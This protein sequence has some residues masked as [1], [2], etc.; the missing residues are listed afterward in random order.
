[1]ATVG[2]APSFAGV[3]GAAALL[4]L[5]LT[6]SPLPR[7]WAFQAVVSG[8][9]MLLGYGAGV[10][11][12]W[13]VRFWPGRFWSGRFW[14]GRRRA[15][16]HAWALLGGLT[17]PL[18][19]WSLYLGARWQYEVRALVGA[20]QPSRLWYLAVFVLA[21]LVAAPLVAL[22]RLVRR[23]AG[24]ATALITK[25]VAVLVAVVL[26]AG[27]VSGG[28]VGFQPTGATRPDDSAP[29]D[30]MVSGGRKSLLSWRSLGDRGRDFVRFRPS[31]GEITAFTGRAA[32]PPIRVYAG[33]GAAPTAR[34]RAALAVRELERTGAFAR[35]VLC[36]SI[37]TGTGWIDE[38][39]TRT[40]EFMYDG[41]TAVVGVQYSSL[42]SWLSF[43]VDRERAREAGR[44]LFNAVYQRWYRLP[45]E[46]R[47]KL[48][49]FGESL[50]AY[51]SEG[52][53]ASVVD[54]RARTDGALWVGSPSGS[55]LAREAAVSGLADVAV[56]RHAS[57]PVVRFS[58]RL[59]VRRPQRPPGP[60][61][62]AD[63]AWIPLVTYLQTAADLAIAN[64]A[65]AG[66]GH[67]YGAAM[68]DAWATIA[69]PDGWTPAQTLRLKQAVGD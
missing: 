46:R 30:P 62:S 10:L 57:D 58:P 68:V 14:S 49:V 55:R 21:V 23:F 47:P 32:V 13:A 66:H 24:T 29:D 56:L 64:D 60:D 48:L 51:G 25:C 22:A 42:P 28:R 2:R 37:G 8:V 50:G 31:T 44:E 9:F 69:P 11:I 41:D 45:P 7:G 43:L 17:A 52:A 36:V 53:F 40:L 19:A 1:M 63:V 6:P 16:G 35:S 61:S 33:L 38:R 59:L 39:A 4:C 15:G 5:S 18:V 20:D 65:P 26:T 54:L 34:E 12:G 3:I 67:R 27:A